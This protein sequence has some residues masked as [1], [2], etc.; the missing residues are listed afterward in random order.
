MAAEGAAEGPGLLARGWG[1]L[2]GLGIGAAGLVVAAVALVVT[3]QEK[4][5]Y[6]PAAPGIPREYPFDPSQ[7]QLPFRDVWLTAQ[8]GVRLHA[9][10]VWPTG[11]AR[12]RGPTVLWL[13]ENAGNMAH[14]LHFIKLFTRYLG[15]NVLMLM[16]RGYGASE[17]R[18]TEAGLKLDADAAL[19]YLYAAEDVDTDN[20]VVFGR[21]LG[22]AVAIDLAARNRERVK[23]VII[24]NTFTS[25]TDMAGRVLPFLAPFVGEGKPCNFLCRNQWNSST[26]IAQIEVPTLML[27]SLHD[28]MVPFEQMQKLRAQIGTEDAT[29]HEFDAHHMD[30]YHTARATYWPALKAWYHGKMECGPK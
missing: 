18:P 5:L 12:Q 10:Y 23:G 16:Y 25:I 9:W 11:L 7:Y 17:G 8:D 1:L 3:F 28:E 20:L 27:A 22:G 30:A 13:Q 14:R 15:C 6:V 21:S 2:R 26:A 4:L 29:W 24:E 19:D